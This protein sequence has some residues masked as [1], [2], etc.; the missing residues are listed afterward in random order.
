MCAEKCRRPC[1]YTRSKSACRS[2]RMRRGNFIPAPPESPLV[3]SALT[4]ITPPDSVDELPVKEWKLSCLLLAEP[5]LDRNPLAALRAPARD[6]CPP[7]LGLHP[8]AK[9]MRLRAVTPV[10][11]ERALGHE[12]YLLL[13]GKIAT[14]QTKSINE[15]RTHGQTTDLPKRIIR[16]SRDH[17]QSRFSSPFSCARR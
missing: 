4:T 3:A 5:G 16:W 14:E 8:G 11:L 10:G 12:T 7:A 17:F 2:S 13:I 9:S 1:W 6:D 15:G